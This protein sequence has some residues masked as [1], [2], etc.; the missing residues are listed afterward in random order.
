MNSNLHDVPNLYDFLFSVNTKDDILNISGVQT[1]LHLIDF[2][3][4]DTKTNKQTKNAI[5]HGA[6]TLNFAVTSLIFPQL[7]NIHKCY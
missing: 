2:Y 4:M 7:F 3:C 6:Q 5:I 1:T